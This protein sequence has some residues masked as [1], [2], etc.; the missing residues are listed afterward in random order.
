MRGTEDTSVADKLVGNIPHHGGGRVT[1]RVFRS[2]G[3]DMQHLPRNGAPPTVPLKEFSPRRLRI[4]SKYITVTPEGIHVKMPYSPIHKPSAYR[5]CWRG[6]APN[7]S[8]YHNRAWNLI[9]SSLARLCRC[10]GTYSRE[11]GLRARLK[12]T[13]LTNWDELVK[14]LPNLDVPFEGSYESL[15]YVYEPHPKKE[16][17]IK[18]REYIINTGLSASKTWR[19]DRY[20]RPDQEVLYKVKIEQLPH[21]KI[22][23]CIADLGPEASLVGFKLFDLMKD[24][25][26]ASQVIGGDFTFHFCKT[27]GRKHMDPALEIIMGTTDSFT[28]FSD[29]AVY[30]VMTPHGKL[31]FNVDISKSDSSQIL[32]VFLLLRAMLPESA[33]RAMDMI[34]A[35][36][37]LG[38]NIDA[39]TSWSRRFRIDTPRYKGSPTGPDGSPD[40]IL[41]SGSTATTIVN[42]MANWLIG[43][44]LR[45]LRPTTVE[46]IMAAAERVGYVVKVDP[47]PH[48]LERVQFLK[49]SPVRCKD[50]ATGEMVYRFVANLGLFF[51]AMGQCRQDVPG[52]RRRTLQQRCQ[53]MDTALARCFAADVDIPYLTHDRARETTDAAI[54]HVK[55]S[56]YA[57]KDID[58]SGQ[59]KYSVT[60]ADYLARYK[61]S[62]LPP[63]PPYETWVYSPEV[64]EILGMDYG[65][66]SRAHVTEEELLEQ[67]YQGTHNTMPH[68][69]EYTLIPTK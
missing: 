19:V 30:S 34:I 13:I 26:A 61:L 52:D 37:Y 3:I 43:W 47:G 23:R 63:L 10:R 31:Y 67:Y 56:R 49:H 54:R 29:D 32:E 7:T 9:P 4:N 51:R 28:C 58:P 46:G 17:R 24:S 22:P 27:S 53:D 41:Q 20:G 11:I 62:T 39:R 36:H 25:W 16:L 68:P 44:M 48:T 66:G 5:T 42:V 15:K 18:A 33:W 35:Q 64:D 50:L 57:W 6:F 40:I 59:Y 1:Q 60:M 38:F 2:Y 55:K 45:Q 8:V 21:G 65:T 69:T 12:E 14:E